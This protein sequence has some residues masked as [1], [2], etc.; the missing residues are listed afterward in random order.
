MVKSNSIVQALAP[1]KQVAVPS[2]SLSL[3]Y[4]LWTYK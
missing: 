3:Q 4:S 2:S 1:Y